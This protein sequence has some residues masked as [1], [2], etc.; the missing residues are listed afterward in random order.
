M[1]IKLYK[2]PGLVRPDL[3]VGWPGIGNA[4]LVAVDTLKTELQAEEFGEIEPYDFFYP[5]SVVIKAGLLDDLHFPRSK[6]YFKRLKG[7]DLIIFTGEEQPTDARGGYAEGKK[8]YEM[9][10]LVLDVAERFNCQRVYT[11][12]AAVSLIHH[13][14]RPRVWFVPNEE[15][16][17]AD[18]SKLE[19]ILLMSD[20]AG[21][22]GQGSITGLNGLLLGVAKKRKIEGICLMGEVPDYLSGAPFPYPRAAKSVLEAM[23]SLLGITI[24]YGNLDI[25][26][27]RVEE[28]IDNIYGHFPPDIKSRLEQ[29]QAIARA[30]PGGITEEDQKWIKEHIDE[31]FKRGDLP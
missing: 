20:V 22:G 27:T 15:K 11:S 30:E 12:G 16:L 23:T 21:I 2:E 13:A 5:T 28:L 14:M 4:G 7:K 26:A 18:A 9:A 24:D 25:M 1:G 10:N 19:N 6:F 29:R 8:A 3:I 17:L 31:F